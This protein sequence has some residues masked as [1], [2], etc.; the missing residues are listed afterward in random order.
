[1]FTLRKKRR[2]RVTAHCANIRDAHRWLVCIAKLITGAGQTRKTMLEQNME[3]GY[4]LLAQPTIQFKLRTA[5][6]AL[7]FGLFGAATYSDFDTPTASV[8]SRPLHGP[9]LLNE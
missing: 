6:V 2:R 5:P 3:I 4:L 1:M 7:A 9:V 8:R